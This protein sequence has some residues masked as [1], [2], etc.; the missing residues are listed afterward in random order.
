MICYICHK[1]TK[2]SFVVD[3]VNYGYCE[4]HLNDVRT[5]VVKLML[6]HNPDYLNLKKQECQKIKYDT[7][8][9]ETYQ[10]GYQENSEEDF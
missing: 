2:N 6:T 9:E 10:E 4:E 1:N 5:G 3:K 8:Q 7:A